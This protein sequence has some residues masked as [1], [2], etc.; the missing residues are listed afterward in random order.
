MGIC[1]KALICIQFACSPELFLPTQGSSEPERPPA[2][3]P[4]IYPSKRL[5]ELE[6]PSG[7]RTLSKVAAQITR[8]SLYS[9]CVN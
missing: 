6:G 8:H 7:H 3:L 4:G 5:S 1:P 9:L 2:L